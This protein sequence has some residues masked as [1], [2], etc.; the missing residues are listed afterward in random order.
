[1]SK[2]TSKSALN[3][4]KLEMKKIREM[5]SI[6]SSL[7]SPDLG[8]MYTAAGKLMAYPAAKS[9]LPKAMSLLS[10][11]DATLRKLVYRMAGRNIYGEYVPELFNSMKTINPAEREQVLQ[12]VEELFLTV[13]SPK[14]SSEQ[15]RWITSLSQVGHEHQATVFGIMAS[16]GATGLKWVKS[17]IKNNIE[18]VSI[19]TIPKLR[20]FEDKNRV[21]LVK[22]LA[23]ASSKKKRELLPYICEVVESTTVKYLKSFLEE[24]KWQ[25]RVHVAKAVG[26]VGITSATGLVM[27][28]IADPDWRV[29]Q[30]LLESVNIPDSKFS[31]LVKVLSYLIG[32]SHSRVRGQADR[33]ILEL[34]ITECLGSNLD[35]QRKKLEKQFRVQLLRGASAN[36]D[37]D[38]MWL[39]VEVEDHPI[40]FIS[41]DIEEEGVSLSDL[42]PASEE[43]ETP[44]PSPKLDLMAALLK[45]RTDAAPQEPI[46][47]TSNEQDE[48]G[49][50]VE[51]SLPNTEKFMLTL[52]K[53]SKGKKRG[54]SLKRI[55]K[56]CSSLEMSEEEVDEALAQLERD[57]LVYRSSSGTIKRVDIE[58]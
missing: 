16:L 43:K 57:G 5:R 17:K 38:S 32:D 33:L 49:I 8:T 48:S 50:E 2:K 19:G 25:D 56:E 6:S 22:L 53:L 37:I 35:V 30:E 14:S 18:T 13:G 10:T 55:K 34:G 26:S 31:S 9:L 42:Q 12:G 51:V 46:I 27:D 58:L 39:G 29:K 1:M 20:A 36:K 52:K 41:D 7:D 15:K 21:E 44:E 28:I 24:G 3:L 54:V 23:S 40:P 47:P 11:T 4:E 45:A